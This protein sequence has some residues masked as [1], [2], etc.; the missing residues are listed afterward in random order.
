MTGL[1]QKSVFMCLLTFLWSSCA[2]IR[3]QDPW[4]LWSFCFMESEDSNL[5]FP[6]QFL[7]VFHF[8]AYEICCCFLKICLFYVYEYTV[9]IFRHT[10]QKRASNLITDGCEPPC[11]CWEL[12]SGPLKRAVSALNH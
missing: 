8:V 12:S 10:H 2:G 1:Y 11:G 3:G 6:L 9:A 4:T 5:E 7:D